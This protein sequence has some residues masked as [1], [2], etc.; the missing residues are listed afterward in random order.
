MND[1]FK[2]TIAFHPGRTLDE[3][4][5]EMNMSTVQFSKKTN[6]PEFIINNI[7]AGNTS[8]T[9]DMALA[10]E[11]ETLIPAHYW[12]NSQHNFDEYV[13]AK[14]AKSYHKRIVA[15][16]KSINDFLKSLSATPSGKVASILV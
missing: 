6:I 15:W 16:Q 11:K 2:P 12:L 5:K 8:V 4:L 3:K 13:L 1:I 14:E 9:A 7:I 10:F